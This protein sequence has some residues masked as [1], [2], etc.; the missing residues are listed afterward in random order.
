MRAC[1]Y[2]DDDDDDDGECPEGGGSA[3]DFE[4]TNRFNCGNN[5]QCPYRTICDLEA[6]GF[7]REDDCCQTVPENTACIQLFAPVIC[8]D[9][10]CPYD[11]IC[12]AEAS[13]YDR[14]QCTRTDGSR[15]F[16]ERE[17]QDVSIADPVQSITEIVDEREDLSMF[18]ATLTAADLVD[19]LSMGTGPFTIFAPTNEAFERLGANLDNLLKEENKVELT[20]ALVYHTIAGEALLSDKLKDGESLEMA[21]GDEAVIKI[22]YGEIIKINSANIIEA[23]I[24]ATNGVIH[25]V[26][27]V[28]LPEEAMADVLNYH[29]VVDLCHKPV[30][31]FKSSGGSA[32]NYKMACD[33][34]DFNENALEYC[35]MELRGID[36]AAG[37]KVKDVCCTECGIAYSRAQA[38]ANAT[39][40]LE[41]PD[42]LCHKPVVKFISGGSDGE[43]PI[44]HKMVC[45]SEDF[46]A[47]ASEYC[48]M[49]LRG[50]DGAAGLKVKDVC[51][52]ECEIADGTR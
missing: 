34:E 40:V 48:D 19:E 28:L 18:E 23:N 46:K 22:K 26:D 32:M 49:G 29:S 2:A 1:T 3:C 38:E 11:N 41:D 51:C 33:S 47:N 30:A 10:E 5:L 39:I 45:N 25:V 8:G 7:D 13:G 14:A 20:N 24:R 43:E 12:F 9:R 17:G 21:Q 4:P 27:R 37:R 52:T 44:H 36:G 31:K 42:D 35:N 16:A 50:A 15:E 6:A